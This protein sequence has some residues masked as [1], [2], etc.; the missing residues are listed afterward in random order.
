MPHWPHYIDLLGWSGLGW[1]GWWVL[2][3][4]SHHWSQMVN[5]GLVLGWAG[6]GWLGWAGGSLH[7][8]NTFQSLFPSASL[9]WVGLGNCF[10]K[11]QARKEV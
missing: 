8:H 11:F 7:C 1:L 2:I 10:G 5:T 4:T 6:L 9:G 3:R